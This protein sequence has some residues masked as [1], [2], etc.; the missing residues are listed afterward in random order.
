M[1]RAPSKN[2]RFRRAPSLTSRLTGLLRL[3]KA[4]IDK[5]TEIDQRIAN[6]L[7]ENTPT[8]NPECLLMIR[9]ALEALSV[10]FNNTFVE[11]SRQG[12]PQLII[13]QR[14]KVQLNFPTA[15]GVP[16]TTPS[17]PPAPLVRRKS[18]SSR[19]RADTKDRAPKDIEADSGDDSIDPGI[20]PPSRT[21]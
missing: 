10:D 17:A 2:S 8:T 19:I 5:V 20:E 18:T 16:Q 11:Y 14:D 12:K 9:T 13:T 6:A 3:R 4:Y 21:Q 7:R 15:T 1:P